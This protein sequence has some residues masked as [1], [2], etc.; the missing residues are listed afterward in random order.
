[1]LQL[2][3][4]QKVQAGLMTCS[5]LLGTALYPAGA[6]EGTQL[7]LSNYE[8]TFVDEFDTLDVS[9]WGPGTRWIAH[10]PWRGDFGA[11]AFANPGDGFPFTV[12]NGLL[13]IEAR[14]GTDGKWR[15]GLL[16]SV[17]RA[18]NGFSQQYGYF[19]I[20]A[21]LPAGEGVWPAFWLVGRDRSTHTAEI[22]VFEH[23]GRFPYRFTSSVHVWD[24]TEPKKSRSVHHRVPVPP[25]SL[26]EQFHTYGA[27]VDSQQVR[28]YLDR[29]EVWSTATPDQHHQPMYVLLN[30]ALGSGWPIDKTPSPSFML[31]DYVR[32]WQQKR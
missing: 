22:D 11:A 13:R 25:D 17:D 18:G 2:D 31:V 6:Q 29:R 21:K 28:I 24:R 16:A 14:K 19:E 7:D 15:S 23:Q 5:L 8:P 9:P 30:L 12:Q 32:V 26:S 4:R 1:M 20:K 10:T 3:F 27:L